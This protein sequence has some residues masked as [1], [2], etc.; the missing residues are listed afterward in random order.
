MALRKSTE[1]RYLIQIV[2]FLAL[3]PASLALVQ[4]N[5]TSFG[6]RPS[7]NLRAS[8]VD[9]S[10]SNLDSKNETV[11][12]K[13]FIRDDDGLPPD[14]LQLPRHSHDVVNEILEE[15][16]DLIRKMHKHS[17]KVE[18][19]KK[20]VSSGRGSGGAHDTIFANTYVDL[21]KVDTVGFDYDYTLVTYTDEL[22]ELIYDMALK[23]LVRDRQYPAEMLEA[24][25]KFDP[26]FSIRGK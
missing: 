10:I 3:S 1:M 12:N 22:L 7:W 13:G 20:S 4:L 15:T 16:E 9:V 2:S 14:M 24:G 6:I 5:P 21:G 25:L 18:E 26:F 23:R 19:I 8:S 11:T 17:K